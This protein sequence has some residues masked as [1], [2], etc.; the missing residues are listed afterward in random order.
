ML[1]DEPTNHLDLTTIEWLEAELTGRSCAIVLISHD[2]RFLTNLSR[3]TAWL[4]RGRI[5]RLD[6]G[7]AAFEEWRDAILAEEEREQHKLDR[8]IVAE[9]HWL[10]Y[11]V[12]ARRKR[13]VRRLGALQALRQS[14]REYRAVAGKV[15][16]TGPQADK[17]GT[18]W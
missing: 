3:G 18:R 9:E 5:R 10:R 6:R 15:T 13:N 16:L 17:S 8:K 12:T 7:F 1:L 11:G 2:R 14:R 4:D